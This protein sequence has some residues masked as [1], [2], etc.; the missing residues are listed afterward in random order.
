[1]DAVGLGLK[2]SL[3]GE[4]LRQACKIHQIIDLHF[5]V[6][7]QAVVWEQAPTFQNRD[8]LKL[9]LCFLRGF[10]HDF[11]ELPSGWPLIQAYES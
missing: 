5:G 3:K 9:F 2:H 6:S 4:L 10:D 7:Q 11:F 1:M 8:L